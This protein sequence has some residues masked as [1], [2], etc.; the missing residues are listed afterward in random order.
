MVVSPNGPDVSNVLYD[1]A[2]N[3]IVETAFDSSITLTP[4]ELAETE[5][6][7]GSCSDNALIY[8]GRYASANALAAGMPSSDYLTEWPTYPDP[9][10]PHGPVW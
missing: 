6:G 4:A 5:T 2:T 10:Y 7:L 1:L 3:H 9:T 8:Y